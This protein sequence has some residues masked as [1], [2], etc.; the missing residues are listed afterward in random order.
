MK[1]TIGPHIST[2]T[3]PAAWLAWVKGL[4]IKPDTKASASVPD[5]TLTLGKRNIVRV[6]RALKEVRLSELAKLATENSK[7]PEFMY[8]LFN[9]RKIRITDD[10]GVVQNVQPAA[11]PKRSRKSKKADAE[12]RA[13]E[14]GT[15]AS[16]D[17][18]QQ[19][20]LATNVFPQSTLCI[21]PGVAK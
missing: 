2:Y 7:T 3:D 13:A 5:I 21:E 4:A 20:G 15:D 17:K 12:H 18:L 8:E 19:P 1:L 6:N 10:L 14:H 11:K 16:E 9:K